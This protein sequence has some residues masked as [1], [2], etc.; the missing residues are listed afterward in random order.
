MRNKKPMQRTVAIEL[1]AR[2]VKE[3]LTSEGLTK[4]TSTILSDVAASIANANPEYSA[5]ID[6]IN[7]KRF[8]AQ[9]EERLNAEMNEEV[10]CNG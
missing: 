3:R 4:M 1:T 8:T 2:A 10:A 5:F 7:W 6:F 9:V